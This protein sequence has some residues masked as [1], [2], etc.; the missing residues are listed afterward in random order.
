MATHADPAGG[1]EDVLGGLL[2]EDPAPG[3]G[4]AHLVEGGGPDEGTLEGLLGDDDGDDGGV[5]NSLMAAADDPASPLGS[6]RTTRFE[7][8]GGP[9]QELLREIGREGDD[10]SAED[11]QFFARVPVRMQAL[12]WE[13]LGQGGDPQAV[14]AWL[15]KQGLKADA[16][17][18]IRAA[19]RAAAPAPPPAPA[20]AAAPAPLRVGDT[21]LRADPEDGGDVLDGLLSD[22]GSGGGVLDELLGDEAEQGEQAES[23]GGALGDLLAH[24]MGDSRR[25]SSA[26]QAAAEE[27]DGEPIELLEEVR[28]TTRS[29][30][31]SPPPPRAGKAVPS[32]SPSVSTPQ[33]Q[34]DWDGVIP[35]KEVHNNRWLRASFSAFKHMPHMH[36]ILQGDHQRLWVIDHFAGTFTEYDRRG[37]RRRQHHASR[38]LQVERH[39][40]NVRHL[41]LL[42]LGAGKSYDLLLPSGMHRERFFEVANAARPAVRCVAPALLRHRRPQP[43]YVTINAKGPNKG[44]TRIADPIRPGETIEVPLEGECKISCGT[45]E[46]DVVTLWS[47]TWN[48]GG[49]RPRAEDLA[50]WLPCGDKSHDLYCVAAQECTWQQR[51]ADWCRALHT[52]L[53]RES[54]MV[55]ASHQ[56]GGL[57]VVLLS[58]KRLLLSVTNVEGVGTDLGGGRSAAGMSLRVHNTAI[59]FV[60]VHIPNGPPQEFRV[61]QLVEAHQL[62]CTQEFN[63][64]RGKIVTKVSDRWHVALTDDSE[65]SPVERQKRSLHPSNLRAVEEPQRLLV[66]LTR[67]LALLQ[68]GCKSVDIC[69]QFHHVFLLGHMGVVSESSAKRVL[70]LVPS[71]GYLRPGPQG[72][73]ERNI[74]TDRDSL[75][76]GRRQGVLFGFS[77]ETVRFPPTS[78]GMHEAVKDGRVA[79]YSPGYTD[80][81]LY[82]NLP[83]TGLRCNGYAATTGTATGPHLPV[84]A[85][86]AVRCLRPHLACFDPSPPVAFELLSFKVSPV[87]R[88]LPRMVQ[89][90]LWSPMLAA[91]GEVRGPAADTGDGRSQ[92]SFV[93]KMPPVL[94]VVNCMQGYVV[95]QFVV[96][97][98]RNAEGE[99]DASFQSAAPVFFA[100]EGHAAAVEHPGRELAGVGALQRFGRTVGKWEMRY[101]FNAC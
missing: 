52:H 7:H 37:K 50:K 49:V 59:A 30:G 95:R 84:A 94:R 90:A 82:R 55:L 28:D 62:I 31:R 45:R 65:Q 60:A 101:R 98:L 12:A 67:A 18:E 76:M 100:G 3:D 46:D 80:R 14:L 85:S 91:D 17:R 75:A 21:P 61:G 20:P 73:P 68:L 48:H 23:D 56:V 87:Q 74:I 16:E 40:E 11:A 83:G 96:V 26:E 66:D 97:I 25:G 9:I 78:S 5:L 19:R 27:D 53:G 88:A 72:G 1:E 8:L 35:L 89:L 79:T 93:G 10:M 63:G 86:F 70:Q 92:I 41:R 69:S 77:E 43:G 58:R 33:P 22:D 4:Q 51:P 71:R 29:S 42:F 39:C 34:A 54:F 81:V 44:R 6:P 24:E 32:A 15:R 64:V 2:A 13:R 57:C 47:G 99:A 36:Q 38:L